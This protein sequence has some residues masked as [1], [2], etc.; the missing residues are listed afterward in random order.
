MSDRSAFG[1]IH[2]STRQERQNKRVGVGVGIGATAGGAAFGGGYTAA[3]Y[4]HY[5][6]K[7]RD[8]WDSN[9][10]IKH[11]DTERENARRQRNWAAS[12]RGE[13]RRTWV[14]GSTG[15]KFES[16]KQEERVRR[17]RNLA[18]HES[19]AG[20]PEGQSAAER[21]K[22]MGFS[23]KPAHESPGGYRTKFYATPRPEQMKYEPK[24]W[25]HPGKKAL[26]RGSMKLRGFKGNLASSAA[27]G[28]VAGMYGGLIGGARYH[29][30]KEG[31]GPYKG[32]KR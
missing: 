29:Q 23:S 17:L 12:G 21:L 18:N 10:R 20:T 16:P 14:P 13:Y 26:L 5:K 31:I 27:T 19:S 8:A 22:R 2:K 15:E 28:V 6:N 7:L 3:N 11:W 24:P 4:S 1:V 25:V 9:E 32:R 30:K